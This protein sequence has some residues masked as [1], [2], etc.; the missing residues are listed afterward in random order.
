MGVRVREYTS[1]QQVRRE[2]MQHVK[3]LRRTLREDV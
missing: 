2:F 1:C 3:D